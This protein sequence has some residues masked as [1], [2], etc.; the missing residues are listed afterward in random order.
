MRCSGVADLFAG[1]V[2]LFGQKVE[3]DATVR[4]DDVLEHLH[5]E[6]ARLAAIDPHPGGR[7][8]SSES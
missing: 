1:N 3:T 6:N 5:A 8:T 7:G 2:D 4:L